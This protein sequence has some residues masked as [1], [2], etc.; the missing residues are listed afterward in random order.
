MEE[1]FLKIKLL[2]SDASDVNDKMK[3]IMNSFENGGKKAAD[4]FKVNVE[5]AGAFKKMGETIAKSFASVKAIIEPILRR[6]NE[7]V[8]VG[9]K[10][11][12]EQREE[13]VNIRSFQRLLG[14][15]SAVESSA[16]LD[17]LKVS[18]ARNP[19]NL[20]NNFINKLEQ[21]RLRRGSDNYD[22][23]LEKYKGMSNFDAF[24]SFIKDM[25]NK[26]LDAG[27]RANIIRQVAG[28]VYS[29]NTAKV[30]S[31]LIGRGGVMEAYNAQ[32]N[33]I[34]TIAKKNG[35]RT[36]DEYLEVGI[37]RTEQSNRREREKDLQHKYSIF[38]K[39]TSQKYLEASEQLRSDA[40]RTEMQSINNYIDS[41][42]LIHIGNNLKVIGDGVKDGG[43]AVLLGF[44]ELAK[45]TV[46]GVKNMK[47]MRD[48]IIVMGATG[49]MT[50]DSRIGGGK[51]GN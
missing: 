23:L 28:Q 3:E 18:D 38:G 30:I 40:R 15:D 17:M 41:A 20:I 31:D 8:N 49:L 26:E 12:E 13:V 11:I 50:L 22:P 6:A 10:N 29:D 47:E 25:S 21:G 14:T 32:K 43:M 5:K 2:V 46:E 9:N 37:A 48:S 34:E 35:Y 39:T 24:L 44:S 51:N 42:D 4:A 45:Y 1:A 36:A 27:I 33:V 7:N 16:I 19:Y